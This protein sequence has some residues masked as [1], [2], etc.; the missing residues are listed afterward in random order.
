MSTLRGLLLL[1]FQSMEVSLKRRLWIQLLLSFAALIFLIIFS[2]NHDWKRWI[3]ALA[4]FTLL[5]LGMELARTI[6]EL[7]WKEEHSVRSLFKW[8]NYAENNGMK[9]TGRRYGLVLLMTY[10]LMTLIIYGSHT[11]LINELNYKGVEVKAVNM[12]TVWR[13]SANK[14]SAGFY[15]TY[16]YRIGGKRYLHRTH[17]GRK[18]NIKNIHVRVLPYLPN[19]HRISYQVK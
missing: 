1:D 3:S 5:K 13:S 7:Q 17:I 18:S 4:F 14:G 12:E 16:C 15:M 8:T 19:V 2:Y 6:L 11:V 9:R 10:G